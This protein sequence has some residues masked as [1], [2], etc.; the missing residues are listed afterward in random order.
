M[1]SS[2][3]SIPIAYNGIIIAKIIGKLSG[4]LLKNWNKI[5][6]PVFSTN[7]IIP[8]NNSLF[9]KYHTNII[10]AIPGNELIR[11]PP[12]SNITLSPIEKT[13]I[14]MN[15]MNAPTSIKNTFP[16]IKILCFIIL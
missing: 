3:N 6:N 15:I 10:S 2:T 16:A 14:D 7:V 12:I 11:N 8:K 1:P 4:M 5:K 13:S 9:Q